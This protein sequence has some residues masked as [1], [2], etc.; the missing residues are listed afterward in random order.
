MYLDYIVLFASVLSVSTLRCDTQ[1]DLIVSDQ[2][3]SNN[4]KY[5]LEIDGKP[6]KYVPNERYTLTIKADFYLNSNLKFKQFIL[7]LESRLS[8]DD[9]DDVTH[10]T[11]ILELGEDTLSKFSHQCA[12]TVTEANTQP[13]KQVVLFWLAPPSNSGCVT[14][15]ATV[16][17]TREKWYADEDGSSDGYLTK[18]LCESFE[19]NE[20]QLPEILTYCC[21]CD[22]AKYEMAFKGNWIRNNHPNGFPE[23]L[24]TTRFS[25]IVGASHKY[26]HEFWNDNLEPSQGLKE[27]AFNGSTKT[28]EEELMRNIANLHTIIKAKGLSYPNITSSSYA[29]FRVDNE[30]HLVSMV[31]KMMPS[32]DW[33]VGVPSMELCLANCSWK[34]YRTINLYPR[35]VGIDDAVEYNGRSP[36]RNQHP[37]IKEITSTDPDDERSPFYDK[38]GERMKPIA[39][40]HFKLEKIYQKRCN[41]DRKPPD[42][43]NE[44]VDEEEKPEP[45]Y[46][47]HRSFGSS[48]N[49]CETIGW[50]KWS[51]CSA[52]CGKGHMTRSVKFKYA[53]AP[54]TCEDITRE[55]TQECLAE[56]ESG[57]N[58]VNVCANIIWSQWSKCSAKCGKGTKYRYR[59]PGRDRYED[60]GDSKDCVNKEVVVC[61]EDC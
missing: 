23:N 32:P 37:I 50:T 44:E 10:Q 36:S 39:Q 59:I 56:C 31:S 16:I 13:K 9:E 49:K 34:Q 58:Y 8:P 38:S 6:E 4:G 60:E 20:D 53:P 33:I 35:D 17:E 27:L 54:G 57:E 61:E 42:P 41:P 7:S 46:Q 52:Q 45:N 18:T 15:K 5:L 12:N 29:I 3:K 47:P 40:L 25:D 22:E 1:Y 26:G 14:I 51:S 19:E 55:E 48:D 11:G 30:N 21:A 24:F 2:T 43:I 28:L